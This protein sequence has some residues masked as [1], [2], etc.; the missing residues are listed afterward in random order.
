MP[1]PPTRSDS[2]STDST[3]GTLVGVSTADI[4]AMVKAACQKAAEVL[5]TELLNMFTDITGRLQ[6][7]EQRFLS[8]EQKVVDY[9]SAMNDVSGR[10]LNA[11]ISV[12]AI[13][14]S[15]D[16]HTRIQESLK[17]LEVIRSEARNAMC[18]ANDV[19]QH[20]RRNNIRIR[21][22]KLRHDEDCQT[23]VAAFFNAKLQ[24]N[25]TH[26]DID[27]AHKLPTKP[28]NGADSAQSSSASSSQRTTPTIIVRFKKRDVR[29]SVLR[30][31][32]LLKNSNISIVEDLTTLNSQT[33]N[34]VSKEWEW[35]DLCINEIRS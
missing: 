35:E 22:L 31:R 15:R 24:I 2:T 23:A 1:K 8:L 20:G 18:M 16:S 29:D 4:E 21:G 7:L 10:V 19:E 11:Q 30:K 3:S 14:G 34:R 6:S 32:R 33:L 13:M 5:K 28:D 12:D 26:E 27:A 17:Q 9:D 25:I